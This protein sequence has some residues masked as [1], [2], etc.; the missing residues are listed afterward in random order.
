M[1]LQAS[2]SSAF[3]TSVRVPQLSTLMSPGHAAT[4]NGT[5]AKHAWQALVLL[6]LEVAAAT[7]NRGVGATGAATFLPQATV[8]LPLPLLFFLPASTLVLCTTQMIPNVSLQ[9]KL[10]Q[11]GFKPCKHSSALLSAAAAATTTAVTR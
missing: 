10:S 2:Y 1:R 7:L 6:F 9:S 11:A 4:D 8:L 3:K 5:G